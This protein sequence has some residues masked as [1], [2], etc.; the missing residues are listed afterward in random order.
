MT[1][2]EILVYRAQDKF[3]AAGN[4]TDAKTA[5]YLAKYLEALKAWV[6]RLR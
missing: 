6:L 5:E 3:D 1:Q 4:L 2:P